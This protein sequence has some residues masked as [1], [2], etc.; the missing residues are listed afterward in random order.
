MPQAFSPEAP[1]LMRFSTSSRFANIFPR[2]IVYFIRIAYKSLTLR[3]FV[4]NRRNEVFTYQ[5]PLYLWQK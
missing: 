2:S 4:F 5:V 3:K 1:V